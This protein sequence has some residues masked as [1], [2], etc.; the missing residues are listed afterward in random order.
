MNDIYKIKARKYKLKYLKLKQK[1]ISEGGSYDFYR[2]AAT[3]T[4]IIPGL[5]PLSPLF[6]LPKISELSHILPLEQQAHATAVA[7]EAVEK[8]QQKAREAQEAAEKQA[9]LKK[10]NE[11][12][13]KFENLGKQYQEIIR[14]K[15]ENN[16]LKPPPSYMNTLRADLN[17]LSNDNTQAK[18]R[19][20]ESDP[21]SYIESLVHRIAEEEKAQEAK[22]ANY[23][24]DDEERA[25]ALARARAEQEAALALQARLRA[26]QAQAQTR[27]Q[28]ARTEAR[29]LPQRLGLNPWFW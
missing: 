19:E 18:K 3:V 8:R 15:Q 17:N 23:K 21:P 27:R 2:T 29:V 9:K 4:N 25:R 26:Q 28:T 5:A 20:R 11:E 14:Q 7:R 13:Q 10:F 16:F 22:L 6:S 1:Y 24:K 12:L